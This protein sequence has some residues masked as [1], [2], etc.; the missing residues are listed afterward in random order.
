MGSFHDFEKCPECSGVMS[1][2]CY[3]NRGEEYAH[4]KR[5][6][7]SYESVPKRHE[8]G[9]VVKDENGQW[10][11]QET[12]T[13]GYGSFVLTY[14]NGCGHEGVFYESI[15]E[16]VINDFRTNFEK[17]DVKTDSSFLA[18][19]EDG[20]QTILLGTVIPDVYSMDF[21]E[22]M[23]K[24][25]RDVKSSTDDDSNPSV[26]SEDFDLPLK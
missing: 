16:E 18:K 3:Y 26:S 4:C 5:C 23:K 25:G 20:K 17:E 21:D 19:W 1:T 2:T 24:W 15:T 11:F 7:F 6:G 13:K 8:D 22:L 9:S 14:E 12:K 10:Q